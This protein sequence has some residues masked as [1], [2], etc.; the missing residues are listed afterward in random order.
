M[1]RSGLMDAIQS[2]SVV[3][4]IRLLAVHTCG[5]TREWERQGIRTEGT[6]GGSPSAGSSLSLPPSAPLRCCQPCFLPL[7]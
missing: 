2:H 7:P 5:G 6:C 3:W 4:A 1:R